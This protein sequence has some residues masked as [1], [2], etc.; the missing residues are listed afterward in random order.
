LIQQAVGDGAT[1]HIYYE[2]RLARLDLKGEE[3]PHL[4]KK[5]EEVTEGEEVASKERLQS[6]WAALEA[7]GMEKWMGLIAQDLGNTLNN[8]WRPWR[9]RL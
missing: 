6:K 4:D 2:S 1:V 3:K 9:V 8:G 7:V 5:F